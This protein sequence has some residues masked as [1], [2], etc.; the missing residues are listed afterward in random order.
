M[1]LVTKLNIIALDAWFFGDLST[2]IRVSF[3]L[4]NLKLHKK[5]KILREICEENEIDREE[6]Q[7][8]D[9]AGV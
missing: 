2:V 7:L 8:L 1:D 4:D 5:E 9:M 3:I 6:N